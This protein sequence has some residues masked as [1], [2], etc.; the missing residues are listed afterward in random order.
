MNLSLDTEKPRI[1]KLKQEHNLS[2]FDCGIDPINHFLQRF[3]WQN[4]KSDS[5]QTYIALIGDVVI[6]YYTLTVGEVSYGDAPERLKKGLARYPIPVIILARLAINRNFQGQR[7]G[8]GL[9]V[10]AMR[11]TLQVSD[12]AGIRAIVVHAKDDKAQALY[13]HFGFEPFIDE[14][15]IL[16]RLLK[17]I[18]FML[19][20][21][22]GLSK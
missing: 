9:L 16:Y 21:A 17:D 8:Q 12:I 15:L 22:S 18:R 10:D 6:G 14:S 19:A 4:Q 7:L 20:S 3:A 13:Q 5:S 2:N 11:R 1:E